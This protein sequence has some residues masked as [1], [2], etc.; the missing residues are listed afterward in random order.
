M[1]KAS[2][3][4][5]SLLDVNVL[6]ALFDASHEN[7]ERCR[8]WLA[9]EIEHGWATCAITQN[10]FVRI[11]SQPAYP[12]GLSTASGIDRLSRA[13]ATPYHDYW[14]CEPSLCDPRVIDRRV[15][16][17]HRQV[18]DAYLLALAVHNAG[19]FVT[20]DRRVVLSAAMSA[21]PEQLVVL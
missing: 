3:R 8:T 15:V 4:V 13:V 9:S 16:N 5:R 18:T 12:G 2:E 17:G 19:R 14:A 11:I 21:R 1:K 6:L 20:L 7:H 10:G